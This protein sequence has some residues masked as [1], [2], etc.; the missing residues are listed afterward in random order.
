MYPRRTQPASSDPE[1][2]P[3]HEA[4]VGSGDDVLRGDRRL[5]V[6]VEF[7]QHGLPCGFRTRLAAPQ[8]PPQPRRP[9]PIAL[10]GILQGLSGEILQV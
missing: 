6:S 3:R 10:T 4:A 1:V 2:A 9:M 5:D 8:Q 7:P